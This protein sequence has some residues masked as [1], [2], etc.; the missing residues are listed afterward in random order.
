MN[1]AKS[2]C[3][4]PKMLKEASQT[5]PI[6]KERVSFPTSLTAQVH[7]IINLCQLFMLHMYLPYRKP[8][9]FS[10]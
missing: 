4:C 1:C 3:I 5:L 8:T 9:I 7:K 10:T 2:S 6:T